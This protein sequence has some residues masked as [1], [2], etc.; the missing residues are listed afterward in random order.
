[1]NI[2]IITGLIL[3]FG[4]VTVSL[5]FIILLKILEREWVIVAMA[6]ASLGFTLALSG[7]IVDAI[8]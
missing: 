7:I 5:L 6:L 4:T 2:L 8:F 3:A 1:M